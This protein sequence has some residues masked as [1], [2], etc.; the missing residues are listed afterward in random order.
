M[1][2]RFYEITLHD[3][4]T[5]ESLIVLINEVKNSAALSGVKFL[6]TVLNLSELFDT[7]TNSETNVLQIVFNAKKLNPSSC[8]AFVIFFDTNE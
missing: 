3:K 2:S 7:L 8:D 6:D 1:E 4:S 5:Q